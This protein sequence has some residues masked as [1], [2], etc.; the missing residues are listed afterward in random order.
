MRAGYDARPHRAPQSR[1]GEDRRGGEGG[2]AARHGAAGRWV[3]VEMPKGP[4]EVGG[5][6]RRPRGQG[7]AA[8]LPKSAGGQGEGLSGGGKDGGT[9]R[10]PRGG[11]PRER[12]NLGEQQRTER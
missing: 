1:R 10:E 5:P 3:V 4:G 11:G 8:R 6:L 12:G 7:S 9:L 2:G